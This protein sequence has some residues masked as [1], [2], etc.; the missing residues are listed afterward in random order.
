MWHTRHAPVHA[1][2]VTGWF[3]ERRWSGRRG[4]CRPLGGSTRLLLCFRPA[5][6]RPRPSD[7]R[8]PSDCVPIHT[9][10]RDIHETRPTF[11]LAGRQSWC[12]PLTAISNPQ[13]P[14][15][16]IP[17][18]PSTTLHNPQQPATTL[19]NPPQPPTTPNNLQQ[20]SIALNNLQRPPSSSA[21]LKNPPTALT[22]R[23]P[24][25]FRAT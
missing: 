22:K 13:P 17:Q 1:G 23:G 11:S 12:R 5:G 14:S 21:T 4:M 8:F 19:H 3:G 25:S 24:F 6:V 15:I 7:R 9:R 2:T 18:Q 16:S 10:E 20:P